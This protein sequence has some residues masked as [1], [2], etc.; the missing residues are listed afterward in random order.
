M[1]VKVREKMKGSGVYW[2][3]INHGGK[4]KST[5]VGTKRDADALAGKVRQGLTRGDLGLSRKEKA[6][7]FFQDYSTDWLEEMRELVKQSTHDLYEQL[8]RLHIRPVLGKKRL[9]EISIA[10]VKELILQKHR[11]GLSV[12]TLFNMKAVISGIFSSAIEEELLSFN[13]VFKLGRLLGRLKKQTP[14]KE[15]SPLSHQESVLF[16]ETARQHFSRFYPVLLCAL[17]TGMRIGELFGLEWADIDFNGRF[18]EVRRSMVKGRTETPK[19]GKT[20][21]VDMSKQ[22]TDTLKELKTQRKRETLSKGWAKIPDRVFVGEKGCTLDSD[23][24]RYRVFHKVL[25]KAGL[26]R[27]R[28]HD[29]RHTY[30]SFLIQQGESLAYIRDQLGHHSIKVTVDTYGHIEP[31]SNRQAVD[32]LDD[33]PHQS[34]PQAHP[35]GAESQK[36]HLTI[37]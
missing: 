29:M 14:I 22:L 35:G 15:V 6:L 3:F 12:S 20:R 10:D 30:A 33:V 31:G 27:I 4:R 36:K 7:P 5:T 13:P 25:D 9:D 23:N 34:A 2:V 18:I 21:R 32:K 37:R 11:Q 28:I 19:N 24:F 26:R 17:R 16:L 1:G 8:L